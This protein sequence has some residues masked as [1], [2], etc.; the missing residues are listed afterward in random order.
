MLIYGREFQVSSLDEIHFKI[1][2][3]MKDKPRGKALDFPSGT[4]RLSWMLYNEGFE[5]VAADIVT[6]EF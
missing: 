5:V 1:V 6:D 4:G 3:M 2:E